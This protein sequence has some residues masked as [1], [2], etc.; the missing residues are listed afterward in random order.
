MGIFDGLFGK[1][2][3]EEKKEKKVIPWIPLSSLDQLNE[4]EEKS[5]T[6][7]QIIFKHSTTCGISRMV[8]NTFQETYSLDK[9]QADLYYLDL[10]SFRSVSNEVG[11]KFQ[12]IHQSPQLLVL[13]EGKTIVHASHGG[14][15]DIVLQEYV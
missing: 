6:K 7:A 2:G 1:S 4:I 3:N 13:K 14:I 9:E 10:H 12:V 8:M 15:N 11:I 5:K